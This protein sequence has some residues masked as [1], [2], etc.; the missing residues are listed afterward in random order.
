MQCS[1]CKG[2]VPS[3][4]QGWAKT[5]PRHVYNRIVHTA[6]EM[7]DGV[8][9]EDVDLFDGRLVVWLQRRGVPGVAIAPIDGG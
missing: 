7:E 5:S 6:L 8:V 4:L 3:L 2:E 9:M 1:R